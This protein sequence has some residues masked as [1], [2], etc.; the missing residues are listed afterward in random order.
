MKKMCRVML[1]LLVMA[2]LA[3][4]PVLAKAQSLAEAGGFSAAVAGTTPAQLD[5]T[6]TRPTRTTKLHSGPHSLISRMHFNNGRGAPR[7]G[8]NSM[9]DQKLHGGSG[10]NPPFPGR[11]S[12]LMSFAS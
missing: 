10:M 4:L 7:S 5:L 1:L 2:G 3:I 6:Y 8:S 12:L 11:R 9:S